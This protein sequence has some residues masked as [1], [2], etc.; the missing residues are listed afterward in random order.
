M[1]DSQQ[2]NSDPLALTAEP[3][4]VL[5]DGN[6]GIASA[7]LPAS[8]NIPG[9]DDGDCPLWEGHIIDATFPLV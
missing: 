9:G 2:L 6:P 8:G 7:K 3:E 4:C 1:A 5:P